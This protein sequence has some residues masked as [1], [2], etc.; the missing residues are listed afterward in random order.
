M[1]LTFHH[2]IRI[3]SLLTPSV[4]V[5]PILNLFLSTLV[6]EHSRARRTRMSPRVTKSHRAAI[7]DGAYLKNRVRYGCDSSSYRTILQ[8]ATIKTLTF[9]DHTPFSF[10]DAISGDAGTYSIG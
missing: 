8:R 1:A 4:Q 7:F 6:L 5:N 9:G 2:G 10:Y 3:F